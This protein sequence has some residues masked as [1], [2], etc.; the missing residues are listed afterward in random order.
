[1]NLKERFFEMIDK[2][3][4]LAVLRI[5]V[6]TAAVIYLIFFFTNRFF[7]EPEQIKVFF[8]TEDAMYLK[9]ENREIEEDT[10]IYIQIIEEL[11]AG[12]V[13]DSLRP[14]IPEGVEL[15]D[16]EIDEQNIT[17]NF[18]RELRDNHW[19]GSTG[20]LLTVYSIVN[21]YTYLEDLDSVTIILEGQ[22]IET[23]VGHLDLT[24][25]LVYNQKLV[26]D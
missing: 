17:L 21:S 18:N 5:L 19:G 12:P 23:L 11:K 7:G 3:K 14:T 25:P 26:M 15:L 2:R 16:Y 8:S 22:G 20:E 24:K 10:E 1:M 6:L 4:I 9:A 13:S